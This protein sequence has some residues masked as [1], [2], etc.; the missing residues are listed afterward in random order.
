MNV[1]ELAKGTSGAVLAEG[2]EGWDE[3]RLAF[4]LLIDQRPAGIV[5]PERVEDVVAAIGFASVNDLRIAAQRTGHNAGPLGDLSDTLLVRTD[6]LGGATVEPNHRHAAVGPAARWGDVTGPASEAGLAPLA[7]SSPNVGVVGYTLGGGLSWLG[8]KHGLACN[9]VR[10][11]QLVNARGEVVHADAESEP[12]LFWALRGG[13][14]GLGVV[15]GIEFD[16]YEVPQ[17]Y[18][19]ML[20]WPWERAGEVLEAWRGWTGD[21]PEEAMSVGRIVQIPPFEEIPELVRGKKLAIVEVAFLGGENEGAEL[22]APLREL[23]PDIDTFAAVPPAALG[24]LHMDPPEP[25]PGS[26]DHTLLGDLPSEAISALVDSAGPNSDSPL[27]SVELRHLGGA[28]AREPDGAGVLAKI[29]GAFSLFA[30]GMV[31]DEE[32][33]K[34][35]GAALERVRE[36]HS[37][38]ETGALLGNF[39]ERT[40]EDSPFFGREAFERLCGVKKANDPDDLFRASHPIPPG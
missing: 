18:A 13:G 22:I 28:L 29:D 21:A 23:G 12:D 5:L 38:W 25:V 24:F 35:V 2:D 31:A 30:V 15:T 8:R 4:N 9:S 1:D 40:M 33:G 16:L 14:G 11:V 10:A 19:G 26:T 37:T 3:A 20:A 36:A 7:G 32:M 34:A 27:V 6:R 39:C 17:L